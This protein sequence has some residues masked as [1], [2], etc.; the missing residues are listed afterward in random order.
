M[1]A[2]LSVICQICRIYDYCHVIVHD[3][4]DTSGR[5]SDTARGL[6]AN[7]SVTSI[8]SGDSGRVDS[9]AHKSSF[10]APRGLCYDSISGVVV[11][12]DTHN[13]AIRAI[14]ITTGISHVQWYS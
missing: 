8:G 2:A 11:V 12:A 6:L 3:G 4:T 5:T 10:N 13:H 9:N 1:S 7:E 14:G